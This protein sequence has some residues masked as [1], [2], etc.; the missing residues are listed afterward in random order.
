MIPIKG[1]YAELQPNS[2]GSVAV[3]A[4]LKPKLGLLVPSKDVATYLYSALAKAMHGE[5]QLQFFYESFGKD[6]LMSMLLPKS[7]EKK[8]DVEVKVEKPTPIKKVNGEEHA[9]V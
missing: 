8:D 5:V 3:K 7:G 2:G 1:L 6:G 9:E 4:H